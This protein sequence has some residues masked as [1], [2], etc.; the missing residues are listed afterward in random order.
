MVISPSVKGPIVSSRRTPKKPSPLAMSPDREA[1][2]YERFTDEATLRANSTRLFDKGFRPDMD[3]PDQSVVMEEDEEIQSSSSLSESNS[4][5]MRGKRLTMTSHA[6]HSDDEHSKYDSPV[7]T[8]KKS[9]KNV[10]DSDDDDNNAEDD[11]DSDKI[12][13]NNE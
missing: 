5:I 13:S 9:R 6:G 3:S 11:N 1:F 4:S 2:D 12:V 8:K 7:Q 10:I